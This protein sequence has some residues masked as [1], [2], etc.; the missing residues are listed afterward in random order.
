MKENDLGNLFVRHLVMAVPW[1]IMLLIVLFIS[2]IGIKQ[3]VKE[4]IQ[5]AIRTSVNEA[6]NF[7][8]QYSVVVPVKQNIK[9]GVEF[10]AKAASKELREGFEFAA[11]TARKEI[12]GLLADPEVKQDLK[13]ALEYDK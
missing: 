4:G 8:F 5:Y 2:A 10:V 9:E 11:K 1:G 6:A 7:A 12:K 3:Q 13:E